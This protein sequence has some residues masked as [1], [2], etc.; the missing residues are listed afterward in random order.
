M[1]KKKF[2]RFHVYSYYN[3]ESRRHVAQCL[4]TGNVVTADDEETLKSMMIE[5]VEDELA[6]ALEHENIKNLFS[7]P[8]PFDVWMKYLEA[9]KNSPEILP[10]NV[11]VGELTTDEQPI[12]EIE[13]VAVA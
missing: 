4:E 12:N 3:E 8:A 13:M 11:Q 2:I 1:S 6:F 5:V 10:L 9:S 7:T